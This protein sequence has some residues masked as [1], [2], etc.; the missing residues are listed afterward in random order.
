MG[1]ACREALGVRMPVR[2]PLANA[3]PTLR[4]S[5]SKTVETDRVTV[6]LAPPTPVDN[7]VDSVGIGRRAAVDAWVPNLCTTMWVS[8]ERPL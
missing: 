1:Q 6:N 8:S 5:S 2:L 4:A 7:S 3:Y